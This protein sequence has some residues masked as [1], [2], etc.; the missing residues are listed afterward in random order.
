MDALNLARNQDKM[1]QVVI[2][3]VKSDD[4]ITSDQ[5]I[6]Y[7]K[8]KKI[9]VSGFARS[10]LQSHLFEPTSGVKTLNIAI[11]KA[12]IFKPRFSFLSNVFQE[13][14]NYNFTA[15]SADL[16]CYLLKYF[17][18]EDMK[19]LGLERVVVMSERIEDHESDWCY[20]RIN[21]DEDGPRLEAQGSD[22]N[23]EF[24]ASY[25]FAFAASEEDVKLRD[26][27]L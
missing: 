26:F 2:L 11:L 20:F 24:D 21:W 7:F 9:Y 16:A 4:G 17:S 22:E 27:Y 15:P 5:W 13:G 25:S 3:S 18:S 8:E 12:G 23:I 1:Y 6:E 10:M 19:S 14:K